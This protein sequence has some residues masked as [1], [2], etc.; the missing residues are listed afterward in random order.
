MLKFRE[1]WASVL[2]KNEIKNLAP[3]TPVCC[4]HPTFYI[5]APGSLPLALPLHC[6]RAGGHNYHPVRGIRA[7]MCSVRR[8]GPGFGDNLTLAYLAKVV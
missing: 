8:P 7:R 4:I 6:S 5:V 1:I 2:Q 3:H